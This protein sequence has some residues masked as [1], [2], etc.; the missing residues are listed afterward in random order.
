MGS[1]DKNNDF[2]NKRKEWLEVIRGDDPHSITNQLIEMTWDAASYRVINEARRLAPVTPEGKG[3]QLSGLVHTLVDR[4]FFTSQMSAVRRLVDT[5]GIRGA[6][7]V[8]SLDGLLKDMQ[9]NH[10]LFTREA[11]FYAMGLEYDY[12]QIQLDRDEFVRQQYRNGNKSFFI[13][14]KLNWEKNE[15]LH[16]QIDRLSGINQN[17]RTPD[18]KVPKSLFKNLIARLEADSKDLSKYVDKYIAH[19]SATC[20]RPKADPSDAGVT[21]GHLLKALQTI[22]EVASFTAREVLADGCP[23]F[24]ATFVGGDKFI[25]MDRPL[26]SPENRGKIEEAWQKFEQETGKWSQWSIDEYEQAFNS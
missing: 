18:D 3:V 24:L 7:G 22:A 17:K 12:T 1:P 5:S 26:V 11:M 8:Y 16:A 23:T 9:S 10:Q 6:R 15:H 21:L 4:T 20:N 14:E 25:Y 19:A 2:K 13:P